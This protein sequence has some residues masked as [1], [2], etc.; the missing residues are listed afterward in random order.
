VIDQLQR[1]HN[2]SGMAF[3][4][5]RGPNFF[6]LAVGADQHGAAHDSQIRFPEKTFHAAR[7]VGLD[8]VELRIAQ[9]RKVEFLLGLE[10]RLRLDRIRAAAEHDGV[11][12]IEIPFQLAEFN[13]FR[14]AAGRAGL[15]I[16][17]QRDVLAAQIVQRD[18]AA[19]IGP[20]LER[21]RGIAFLQHVLTPFA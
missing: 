16:K 5:R 7:V 1:V 2:L 11:Q 8:H 6:H 4:F 20:Q 18:F 14:G 13:R 3:G 10:F 15:G 17:I 9:Q 19:V 12:F 21:R